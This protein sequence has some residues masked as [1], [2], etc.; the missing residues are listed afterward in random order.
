MSG[1]KDVILLVTAVSDG[2]GIA[3]FAPMFIVFSGKQLRLGRIE[4][5]YP[6]VKIQ[7][8]VIN[9]KKMGNGW[10]VFPFYIQKAK[11]KT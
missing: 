1:V 10:W 4:T 11:K 8:R 5:G 6:S 2:K 7:E 3:L 9:Y